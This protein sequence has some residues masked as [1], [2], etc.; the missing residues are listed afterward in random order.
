M[1]K[2]ATVAEN[3]AMDYKVLSDVKL[4]ELLKQDDQLALTELYYRY[5]DKLL[6][7]ACH[8][9][10]EPL[11]AE[12]VVQD[13]FF[14][15]W[16]HRHSLELKF[17]LSTYLAAAVKYRIINVLDHLYRKRNREAQLPD[18]SLLTEPSA[19]EY[20]FE[21]ELRLRIEATV[22]SLPEKC[23]IIFRM[24]REEGKTYK[25][26][27]AELDIA[28]KTVEA[29]M[30]KALKEIRTNLGIIAPALLVFYL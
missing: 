14:R 4:V 29:H 6:A 11:E 30:S 1:A 25:Q 26:I 15:L 18:Y 3:K 17:T 8:R 19:E 20:L 12:E 27:A 22:K 13:I 7:V 24:S 28:E 23:Q 21:Q 5:W 9:L 16:Q 10:N 2:P